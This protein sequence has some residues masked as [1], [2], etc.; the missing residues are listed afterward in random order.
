[1]LLAENKIMKNYIAFLVGFILGL[2]VLAVRLY[3]H[4]DNR[5]MAQNRVEQQEVTKFTNW[6]YEACARG[7]TS[8]EIIDIDHYKVT[9]K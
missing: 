7:F 8:A 6:A 3:A 5:L 1:M 9:C 2:I 4:I